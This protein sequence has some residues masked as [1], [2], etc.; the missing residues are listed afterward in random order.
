MDGLTVEQR[1]EEIRQLQYDIDVCATFF[2]GEGWYDPL[3][4]ASACRTI[5]RLQGILI[6]LQRGMTAQAKDGE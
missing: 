1:L 6:E 4:T 5:A 3:E 2:P